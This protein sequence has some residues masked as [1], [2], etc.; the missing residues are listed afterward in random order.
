MLKLKKAT[1]K[2]V[3]FVIYSEYSINKMD[4]VDN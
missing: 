2:I 1:I 4:F 3:A